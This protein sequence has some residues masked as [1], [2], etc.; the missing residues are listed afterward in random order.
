MSKW[1]VVMTASLAAMMVVGFTACSGGTPG[2][3]GSTAG[4]AASSSSAAAPVKLTYWN[5]FT[6]PDGPAMLA[7]IDA[8]NKSQSEVV[9]ENQTMPWDQF[10]Q[11]FLAAASSSDGPN[12]I[13]VDP[14]Y[15][16]QY[17]KM[18]ALA[19]TDDFY[20]ANPDIAK[21]LA[22]TAI[23]VSKYN[24]SNYGVPMNQTTLMAYYNK[25]MFD[26]AGISSFPKTWD[27]F[28]AAVPKLTVMGP[29]GVP[30]QYA[31]GLPVH[32]TVQV[33]PMFFWG[34]GGDVVSQDGKTAMLGDQA[35]ID[36]MNFWTDLVIKKQMSPIG[37]S[38]AEADKLFQSGTAAIDITGPW[39]T[40]GFTEAGINYDVAPIPAGPKGGFNF[41]SIVS[42]GITAKCTPEQ[43]AAAEKFFA[44]WL[45]E[46]S[47]VTWSNGSGFPP[48]LTNVPVSKLT[49]P[50]TAKFGDPALMASSKVYLNGVSV[51]GL[52]SNIVVPALQ[53]VLNGESAA[54]VF[55]DAS[56]QIQQ[57]LDAG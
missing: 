37:I 20:T 13:G 34:N 9:I 45:T 32:D 54:T 23:D 22:A 56:K 53:K 48:T 14:S 5:G 11:K 30:T 24:G 6:G 3:G 16:R 35:T 50:F 57:Q 15:I 38:G 17:A 18:G 28:A 10:Y 7:V 51:P 41:A 33:I 36:A 4:G 26:K 31:M 2:S 19:S 27:E 49:N 43:K 8:F 52:D 47:Q 44:Y 40:S 46:D 21:N 29:N 25:D 39:M 12:I 42:F 55:A 1:K